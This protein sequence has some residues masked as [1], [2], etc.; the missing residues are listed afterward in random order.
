MPCPVCK[1]LHRDHT[2]ECEIEAK[3][4]LDQRKKAPDLRSQQTVSESRK[5]QVEITFKL[6]LHKQQEHAA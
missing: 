4:I 1:A 3:A 2:R 5:R 6:R